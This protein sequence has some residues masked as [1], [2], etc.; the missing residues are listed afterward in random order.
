M[1]LLLDVD[2]EHLVEQGVLFDEDERTRH[3]VFKELALPRDLYQVDTCEV[4]VLIPV[5]YN[6]SGNDM[7]WTHPRLVRRDGV[8]IPNTSNAGAS[9]NHMRD[10]REYCRWSRH[11]P[12]G[13]RSAWRSG[14]D[15]VSSILRRI[16]W[17]LRN[18]NT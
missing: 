17:A 2:Y 7:F 3:L 15:D 9:E 5:S 11:W 1:G 12:E 16:D 8:Q 4:L 13:S 14:K 6:Q 10:G 18:P